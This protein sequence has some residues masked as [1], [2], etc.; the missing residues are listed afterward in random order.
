MQ[1]P[2]P[3]VRKTR[4]AEEGQIAGLKCFAIRSN[5]TSNLNGKMDGFHGMKESASR[6]RITGLEAI[7][8]I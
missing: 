7:L 3:E 2:T 5:Q 4:D 6:V 1:P 8:K